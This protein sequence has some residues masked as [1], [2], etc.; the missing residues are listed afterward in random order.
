VVSFCRIR[1]PSHHFSP[2][3]NFPLNTAGFQ[4]LDDGFHDTLGIEQLGGKAFLVSMLLVLLCSV[5]P[6]PAVAKPLLDAGVA[7]ARYFLSGLLDC[8]GLAD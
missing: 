2:E 5:H 1:F 3:R 8:R 4:S 6:M 7:P